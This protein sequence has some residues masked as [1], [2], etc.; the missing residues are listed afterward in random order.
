[1]CIQIIL[2]F[3]LHKSRL[4]YKRI[5]FLT[6]PTIFRTFTMHMCNKLLSICYVKGCPFLFNTL[7]RGLPRIGNRGVSKMKYRDDSV[8]DSDIF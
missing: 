4:K 1:M 7:T 8:E 2:Y 5:I 3:S 6:N